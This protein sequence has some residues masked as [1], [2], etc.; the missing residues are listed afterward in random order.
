MAKADIRMR[1]DSPD[2]VRKLILSGALNSAKILQ[3]SGTLLKL[4]AEKQKLRRRLALN[5]K[6]IKALSAQLQSNLPELGTEYKDEKAEEKTQKP[7]EQHIPKPA[8]SLQH[9]LEEIESRLRQL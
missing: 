2:R 3:T 6:E 9:E 5:L 7:R 4:S 8:A 1:I